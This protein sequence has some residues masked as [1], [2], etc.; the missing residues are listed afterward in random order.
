MAKTYKTS[1]P[2]P[3]RGPSPPFTSFK[4]IPISPRKKVFL[5]LITAGLLLYLF[6][7]HLP[8]PSSPNSPSSQAQAQAAS[9]LLSPTM[10]GSLDL[11][12]RVVMAPMTRNRASEEGIIS[13]YGATYYEQRATDGGLQIAEGTI[14]APEAGGLANV[15]G[16]WNAQQVDAW[17]QVTEKVHAKGGS[18]V[19][20]LWAL[21]RVANPAL[22]PKVYAPS[23]IPSSNGS[24][25]L[26]VMSETDI[27][28]FVEH[29]R[30]AA[31]NAVE[32]GFDGVEVHMSAH[33]F[34]PTPHCISKAH[35]SPSLLPP[36]VLWQIQNTS[37]HRTPPSPYTPHA[38]LLPLRILQTISSTLP[39]INLGFRISPWSA[40]QDMLE[41]EPVGTFGGLVGRVLGEIPGLAYVHVVRP[42]KRGGGEDGLGLEAIRE[43]VREKGK[44]T[45]FIVA[46][47]YGPESAQH[48]TK[49]TSDLVA[50]GR[51]F[52]CPPSFV[53]ESE[54]DGS[55]T[56]KANPDLVRRI[57][58][59]YP[60]AAY[61][62]DTFYSQGLEGYIDY[63][64]YGGRV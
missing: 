42:E 20:Q 5:L 11:K 33:P 3:P 9:R 25:D 18:I 7:I 35:P 1:W 45:A 52:I 13:E 17:K 62:P 54:A 19:C 10:V 16:I 60:L 51:S 27:D 47:G 64:D 21:G 31:V 12:H 43:I 8:R 58:N 14:I 55:E 30:K 28:R 22:A 56:K 48:H 50:F 61:D 6:P 59:D 15:P 29:Y 36:P 39:S 46:G 57:D 24:Q 63:P 32:A 37:N 53:V 26:T 2:G 38:H 49:D 44:G 4:R 34:F 23:D 40:F 41:P